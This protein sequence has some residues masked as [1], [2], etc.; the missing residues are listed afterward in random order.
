ME[1]TKITLQAVKQR[2]DRGEALVFV[3]SRSPA[4]WA[5]ATTQI[6]GAIRVPPDEVQAHLREIPRGQPLITYCT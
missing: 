3:D 5:E 2:L 4:A 6:P 1:P